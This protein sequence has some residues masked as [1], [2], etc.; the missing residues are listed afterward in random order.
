[1]DENKAGFEMVNNPPINMIDTLART[2]EEIGFSPIRFRVEV[3][4]Y[5][6]LDWC[7]TQRGYTVTKLSPAQALQ[8]IEEVEKFILE[9]K[10][11]ATR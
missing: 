9:F 8:M 1:L 7:P 2:W 6:T 11:G 4:D 10:K 5:K 3:W